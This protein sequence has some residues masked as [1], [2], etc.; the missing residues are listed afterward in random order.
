MSKTGWSSTHLEGNI[1]PMDRVDGFDDGY[2]RLE[3]SATT[4]ELAVEGAI[5]RKFFGRGWG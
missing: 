5:I 4:I 1:F 2:G 3:I